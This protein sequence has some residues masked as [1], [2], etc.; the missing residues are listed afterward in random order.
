MRPIIFEVTG[1]EMS[2][3]ERVFGEKQ[4]GGEK[5]FLFRYNDNCVG[6]FSH[7]NQRDIIHFCHSLRRLYI[8]GG[9]QVM[10]DKLPVIV[11][12]GMRKPMLTVC[13]CWTGL[14]RQRGI[15]PEFP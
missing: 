10:P 15:I 3:P 8:Q 9:P 1:R 7:D 2:V 6:I 12:C 14:N 5:S 13:G 4:N 11:P